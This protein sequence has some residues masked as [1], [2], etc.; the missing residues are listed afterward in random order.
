MNGI[1]TVNGLNLFH[2]LKRCVWTVIEVAFNKDVRLELLACNE[3]AIIFDNPNFDDSIV[4]ITVEG[5]V[6]YDYDKMVSELMEDNNI[7]RQDA[8]DFIECNTI[9]AITYAGP[10]APIIM[11]SFQ[12]EFYEKQ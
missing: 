1:L 5:N 10:T 2:T 6:V 9:R 11:F 8:I 7:S 12:E 4:G 3:D